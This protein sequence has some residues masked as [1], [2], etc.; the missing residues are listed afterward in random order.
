MI[1]F[2]KVAFLTEVLSY[3]DTQNDVDISMVEVGD[4]TVGEMQVI[5]AWFSWIYSLIHKTSNII[6]SALSYFKLFVTES[7]CWNRLKLR[8]I[9]WYQIA[10]LGWSPRNFKTFIFKPK[11]SFLMENY[12][13]DNQGEFIVF[14]EL[15]LYMIFLKMVIPI[16]TIF[17]TFFQKHIKGE[18]VKIQG[19]TL[20]IIL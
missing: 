15:T 14:Y 4:C 1:N 6:P 20:D 13:N 5:Q 16:M 11:L 19:F 17:V 18:F 10:C 8:I 12:K 3:F 7:W 2:K 9:K